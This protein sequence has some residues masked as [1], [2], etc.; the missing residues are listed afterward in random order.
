MSGSD[1]GPGHP[2]GRVPALLGVLAFGGGGYLVWVAF[3][4]GWLSWI[5]AIA[6]AAGLA[7][8]LRGEFARWRIADRFRPRAEAGRVFVEEGR[9]VFLDG[10][11]SEQV[12][13]D[14]IESIWVIGGRGAWVLYLDGARAVEIPMAATGAGDLPNSLVSLPGFDLAGAA[15]ALGR[16]RPSRVWRRRSAPGDAG[17]GR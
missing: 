11:S 13:L 7:A 3:G 1:R 10:G 17:G 14:D 2:D 5:A 6:A 16:R 8:Y 9:I 15:R 4:G 12:E